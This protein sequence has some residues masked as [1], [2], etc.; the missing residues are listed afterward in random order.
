VEGETVM[1]DAAEPAEPGPV[2]IRFPAG[3]VQVYPA[4]EA[5]E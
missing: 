2:T 5:G 3:K 1:V 4:P